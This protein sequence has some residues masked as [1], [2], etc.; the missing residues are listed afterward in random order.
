MELVIPI[1]GWI[2]RY[3]PETT[4]T[5]PLSGMHYIAYYF[6]VFGDAKG[7]VQKMCSFMD[8]VHLC[9]SFIMGV[10][11][12]NLRM[13]KIIIA[14]GDIPVRSTRHVALS[15]GQTRMGLPRC[16]VRMAVWYGIHQRFGRNRPNKMVTWQP[17]KTFTGPGR[18]T[19][20]P[21]AKR[22]HGLEHGPRGD[23]LI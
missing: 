10:H 11:F 15:S 16:W 1:A 3:S 2:A 21:H 4:Y 13:A 6:K 20:Y 5:A 9:G 17:R 18:G 8:L 22:L 14:P 19:L 7:R 12:G 23:M